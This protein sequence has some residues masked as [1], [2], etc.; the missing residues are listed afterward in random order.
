LPDS[1]KVADHAV[2]GH[3]GPEFSA[4]GIGQVYGN[5]HTGINLGVVDEGASV[6][7]YFHAALGRF[8]GNDRH[9]DCQ[10]FIDIQE[11]IEQ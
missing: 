1:A 4:G 5:G 9:I 6:N 11:L 3:K 7:A 2:I 10:V 8:K